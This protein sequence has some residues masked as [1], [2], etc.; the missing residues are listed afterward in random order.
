MEAVEDFTED[1]VDQVTDVTNKFGPAVSSIKR[2]G[3]RT[4]AMAKETTLLWSAGCH[5]RFVRDNPIGVEQ[6][7]GLFGHVLMSGGT[8]ASVANYG[9]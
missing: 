2:A 1:V 9:C 3:S 6:Q 8:L 7:D 5:C 4:N